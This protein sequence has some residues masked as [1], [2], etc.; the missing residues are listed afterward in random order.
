MEIIIPANNLKPDGDGESCNIQ[1]LTVG[2]QGPVEGSAGVVRPPTQAVV[3]VAQ[4]VRRRRGGCCRGEEGTDGVRAGAR[5]HAGRNDTVSPAVKRSS[6]SP[7]VE[8]GTV[9][10]SAPAGGVGVTASVVVVVSEEERRLGSKVKYEG[11][12]AVVA[13]T[14]GR[15][16]FLFAGGHPTD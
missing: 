9:V 4:A 1:R 8:T 10:V 6:S 12:H 2:V 11:S 13:N 3:E 5:G 14:R 16:Y 7:V 15:Y